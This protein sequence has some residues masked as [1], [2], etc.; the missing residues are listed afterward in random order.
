MNR[1]IMPALI[2]S[3]LA[4]G[5]A[6]PRDA[7]AQ[8]AK[9]LSTWTIRVFSGWRL[10]PSVSRRNRPRRALVEEMAGQWGLKRTGSPPM[11][12][13]EESSSHP[14]VPYGLCVNAESRTWPRAL[15]GPPLMA[16]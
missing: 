9:D 12:K 13:L 8:T 16:L 14:R 4:L 2:T 5:I 7:V 3:V 6:G 11:L 1:F 10:I 15:A